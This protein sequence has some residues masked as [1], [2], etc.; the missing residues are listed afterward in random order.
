MPKFT[1]QHHEEVAKVL[2][3]KYTE[4]E[5]YKAAST[6]P[7]TLLPIVPIATISGLVTAFENLF[8]ADNPDFN[9]AKFRKAVGA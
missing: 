1:K 3:S 9:S 5:E 2:R 4:F 6:L 7:K 8:K